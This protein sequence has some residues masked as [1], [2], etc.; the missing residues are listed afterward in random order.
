MS[1]AFRIR[2]SDA[3]LLAR[4]TRIAHE[5]AQPYIRD[6]IVGIMFLGALARGYFD[7]AADIDIAIF[8]TP[9]ADLSLQS[10]FLTVDGVMVHC[11]V[12]VY[13]QEF[14]A[15]WNMA[16]RWTYQQGQIFYDPAGKIAQLLEH[17]V[18]LQPEEKKWLLMSGCVLSEWHIN[19][20]TQ[21]WVERG[22]LISAHHMFDAGMDYFFTML[23]GF[24]NQLVADIKWRYYCVEQL[25]QLPANFRERIKETMMVRSFSLDELERRKGVFMGMWRDMLPLIERELQ[26]SFDEMV[27]LV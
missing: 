20:L 18:P 2:S 13:D 6:D 16:K 15:S 17:K 25:A 9:T 21:L 12:E 14:T 8:T 19:R 3:A 22:N 26:L 4:A 11:H 24:N 1:T 5:F 23:F 10:Q 27:P 7:E